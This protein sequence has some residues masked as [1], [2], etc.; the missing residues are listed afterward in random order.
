[1]FGRWNS[2]YVL[3]IFW[4]MLIFHIEEK[5]EREGNERAKVF[6]WS[7]ISE[8]FKN[9]LHVAESQRESIRTLL[10]KINANNSSLSF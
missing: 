1:M 10:R 2:E 3:S 7:L 4:C 8:T 5:R 9:T 6:L